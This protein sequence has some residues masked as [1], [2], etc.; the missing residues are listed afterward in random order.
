MIGLVEQGTPDWLLELLK[1]G[2][3]DPSKIGRIVQADQLAALVKDAMVSANLSA[4]DELEMVIALVPTLGLEQIQRLQGQGQ[5][6]VASYPEAIA[7]ASSRAAA[8][9]VALALEQVDR[10]EVKRKLQ[11]NGTNAISD[12]AGL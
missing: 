4:D 8:G 1:G 10:N 3:L 9:G 6:L 7:A 12:K 5:H 11:S 2:E